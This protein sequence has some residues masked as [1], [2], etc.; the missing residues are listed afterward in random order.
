[1][2]GGV[3]VLAAPR[4]V[5]ARDT[6]VPWCPGALV[7]WCPGALVLAQH[8]LTPTP[9]RHYSAIVGPI[10][11]YKMC[12]NRPKPIASGRQVFSTRPPG[13]RVPE[14]PPPFSQQ[15]SPKSA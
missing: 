11:E 2:D 3:G 14:A 5:H 10:G 7:P 13:L 8:S 4:A 6:E 15:M 1:M 12:N 9:A